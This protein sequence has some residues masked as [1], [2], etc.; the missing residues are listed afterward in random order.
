MT[1]ALGPG[2]RLV[3]IGS[4]TDRFPD[5]LVIGRT[6]T[7]REVWITRGDC[8]LCGSKVGLYLCEVTHPRGPR[9]GW[10]QCMFRPADDGAH[11]IINAISSEIVS[12]NDPIRNIPL[13]VK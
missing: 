8:L 7:C 9:W 11:G 2:A 5:N 1:A 13:V 3:Y 6:Y 4:G 12:A 10:S